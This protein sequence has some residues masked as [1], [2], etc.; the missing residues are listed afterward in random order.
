[1]GALIEAV[2]GTAM[3]LDLEKNLAMTAVSRNTTF[4]TSHVVYPVL[5]A[6]RPLLQPC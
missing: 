1:M 2:P 3:P 4:D 5:L 6:A